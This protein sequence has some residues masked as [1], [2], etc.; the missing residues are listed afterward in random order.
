LLEAGKEAEKLLQVRSKSVPGLSCEEHDELNDS[1]VDPRRYDELRKRHAGDRV[2]VSAIDKYD[3][4]SPYAK[5]VESL[6]LAYKSFGGGLISEA[7]RRVA[8]YTV[9][10]WRER[11]DSFLPD[12]SE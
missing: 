12:L 7:E 3:Q 11:A 1:G 4:T 5:D 9:D 2:A 10:Y 8:L 6:R